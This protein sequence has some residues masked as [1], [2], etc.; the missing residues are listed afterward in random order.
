M[1][2]KASIAGAIVTNA[3]FMLG[4][5]LLIGGLRYHVQEF[6]R[7]G[8]RLYS[9]L[10]LMAMHP[11]L[12]AIAAVTKGHGCAGRREAEDTSQEHR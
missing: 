4:A 7:S 9:G 8:G 2:V 1:L 12:S 11:S 3:L 10:L 5:C 6:N